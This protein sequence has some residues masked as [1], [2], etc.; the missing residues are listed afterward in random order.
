MT[1]YRSSAAFGGDPYRNHGNNDD[2]QTGGSRTYG[3]RR[4]AAAAPTVGSVIR[5]IIRGAGQTL[6]TFGLVVLLFAAYEVYGKAI[7]VNGEQDVL[8]NQLNNQWKSGPTASAP[9]SGK[10][11]A[12]LVIPRLNKRWAVV[13]GV[14]PHDI[15]LS[16]GHYPK[17]QL[18]GQLGNFAV[19]GH[20]IA[21]IFYDLDQLKDG[22]VLAVQTRTDWFIYK[23]SSTE[24]VNP[25]EVSV[26]DPVPHK[27]GA[28]PTQ[29]LITLTTCNPKWDNYE[30][31][32]IHGTL[33]R[34]QPVSQG[35]P[36]EI[37]GA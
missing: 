15:R 9:L 23:V 21:A 3:R 22:D 5:T 34:T 28:T 6:I 27:P 2:R 29:R 30:R 8:N 26:V 10:A 35:D 7:Q 12:R 19:A 33:A 31:L 14:T 11:M 16:P 36:A 24:I 32:I 17:S 13:E 4:H 1:V 37:A 18:P 20:R 25:H